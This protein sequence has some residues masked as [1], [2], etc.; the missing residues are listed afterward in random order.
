MSC[1]GE[2]NNIENLV[3]ITNEDSTFVSRFEFVDFKIV[4]INKIPK[5]K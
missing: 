5:K 2:G 4:D 3:R 1:N